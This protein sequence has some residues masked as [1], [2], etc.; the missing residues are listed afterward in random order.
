MSYTLDD[1]VTDLKEFQSPYGDSSYFHW[2]RLLPDRSSCRG[3]C[4]SPL[5]GILRIS[6]VCLGLL[7]CVI[8]AKFQSPYG[9]S[10]YFHATQTATA[11]EPSECVSLPVSVPLRGFFVFPQYG[12]IYV[13]QPTPE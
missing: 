13:Y 7:G 12:G 10:S 8:N 9:D 11:A 6:T 5:T 4:F 1:A 2:N 3:D